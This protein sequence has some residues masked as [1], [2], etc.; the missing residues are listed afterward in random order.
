M[1]I[2]RYILWGLICFAAL[3]VG[4][5]VW[6]LYGNM[7]VRETAE[8]VSDRPLIAVDSAQ[9][10]SK[11]FAQM[12][13][14][15]A[16]SLSYSDIVTL[17]QGRSEYEALY[18]QYEKEVEYLKTIMSPRV[19]AELDGALA[20][21]EEWKKAAVTLISDEPSQR[22]PTQSQLTRLEE[23]IHAHIDRAIQ[24]TGADAADLQ[25]QISEK[26]ESAITWNLF[27]LLA[28]VLVGSLILV[29]T[30]IKSS[31][32]IGRMEQAA[33]WD[34]AVLS[35][36]MDAWPDLVFVKD[37]G[38][39]FVL[40]NRR[41]ASVIGVETPAE[42]IGKSDFDLFPEEVASQFREKEVRVLQSGEF[43]IG[44]EEFTESKMGQGAWLSNTKLPIVIDDKIVGLVGVNRD[45]TGMKKAEFALKQHHVELERLV[46]EK[47]RELKDK[48]DELEVAL[49]KEREIAVL[50]RQFVSMVS[51]EFRTPLTIIDATAQRLLRKCRRE[52][53]VDKVEQGLGRMRDA[54][55]RLIGLI[56]STLDAT[57]IE[58]GKI[59][60]N[61]TE[62]DV[63]AVVEEAVQMQTEIN[64]G[65]LIE[66]DIPERPIL[67]YG[68]GALL[69]Q[70]LTNLLSNA[71]KYSDSPA[72]VRATCCRQ[73]DGILISVSDDGVGIP[74][75]EI[76][77][78]FNRFFRAST[79]QGKPGTGIG[80]Y[81]VKH[82]VELH[83]GEIG[84]TSQ[85]G[86]GTIFEV[87]LPVGSQ[88]SVGESLDAAQAKEKI[89][90]GAKS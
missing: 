83:Q 88:T 81:L 18:A 8:Q 66:L 6:N 57:R 73:D 45:I 80:L 4:T 62:I 24:F 60:Y 77:K 89:S 29:I 25:R 63:T 26:A 48:A 23:T 16:Q 13:E 28:S 35:T 82:L 84:V 5:S 33:R 17:N 47:T 20:A 69:N 7:T 39:R 76:E 14:I 50:Q 1:N 9:R 70:V 86:V 54:V 49:E 2:R 30:W 53:E 58:L 10:L 72:M 41:V 52:L 19:Q 15:V 64:P 68:D 34:N 71:L 42:L 90:I 51:H 31:R 55:K 46:E 21:G 32:S 74:Q 79:S 40:A 12:R 65:R 38:S 87:C 61:P 22:V 36:L 67:M 43:I 78:L 37:L 27:S 44:E 56:E 59:T 11:L 3:N 75:D 85:E